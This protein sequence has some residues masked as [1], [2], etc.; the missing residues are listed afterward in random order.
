MRARPASRALFP[1]VLLALVCAWF[2]PEPGARGGVFRSEL[3]AGAAVFVIFLFQ[4]ALLSTENL[5]R[6]LSN[7]RLHVFTQGFIFL[8]FPACV[9]CLVYFF[10]GWLDAGLLVGFLY[11]A[12]LPSTIVTAGVFTQLAGGNVAGAVF[13]ASLS[14]LL[15]I[16]IVPFWM[17]WVLSTQTGA[18][19]PLGPVFLKVSALL[20]LP[21]LLGQGLRLR[22][23]KAFEKRKAAIGWL[24]TALICFILYTAFC[25]SVKSG[26]WTEREPGFL[27][28]AF[29]ATLLLLLQI[30]AIA[31]GCL[32]WLKLPPPDRMAAF[33]CASQ[34]TLA[35]GVP[36]L[37]AIYAGNGGRSL[38]DPG[39]VLLPILL[40][41]PLQVLFGSLVLRRL[42]RLRP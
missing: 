39:L 9:L 13:N 16:L 25:D 33:F 24:S 8:V 3:S 10:G 18:L 34:K 5:R 17:A 21:L 27:L 14:N 23:G 1:G 22:F 19:I 32:L 31:W 20:L 40:Y 38:P 29:L 35:M 41:H 28:S 42:H 15:G 2:F 12:I 11:L 30:K 7:A 36:L 26:V 6:D 37:A 4:G